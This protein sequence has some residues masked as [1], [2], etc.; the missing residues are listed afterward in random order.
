MT[1]FVAGIHA[2]GKTF[3]LGP[4]CTALGI[5]H[6]TASQLIKEQLGVSNWTASRQVGEIDENQRALVSAVTRLH[7]EGKEVVLDGHFVLR[8][9]PFLHEK[10]SSEIFAQ[11][12]IRGVLLLEASSTT[13]IERLRQRGD[14][15]WD[16]SEVDAFSQLELMHAQDVCRELNLPLVRLCSPTKVEVE[17]AL[18][19]LRIRRV[20]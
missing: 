1:V 17:D 20:D 14:T 13:V 5:R 8:R 16:Q 4:V 11:L 19:A 3:V 10:I 6:A 2:V 7:D 9:R 18:N 15:S 12:M